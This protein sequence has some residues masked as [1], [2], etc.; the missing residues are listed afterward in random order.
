[1]LRRTAETSGKRYDVSGASYTANL[2]LFNNM[3]A[4][5]CLPDKFK[6]EKS[7]WLTLSPYYEASFKGSVKVLERALFFGV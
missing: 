5:H 1:M 3:Y 7:C 2:K 6:R 4:R